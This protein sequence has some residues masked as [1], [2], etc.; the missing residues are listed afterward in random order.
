MAI[1]WVTAFYVFKKVLPVVIDKAPE[2]L[3]TLE[4]RRTQPAPSELTRAEYSLAMVQE[5]LEALEQLT[6]DQAKLI[7][8]LQATLR[9]TR[10]SLALAWA[11]LAAAV[12]L[13]TSLALVAFL[14]S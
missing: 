3:K 2:L 10:R 1:P 11:V 13:G 8:L 9:G 6:T 12:L 4:R 7:A 5:R 14:R